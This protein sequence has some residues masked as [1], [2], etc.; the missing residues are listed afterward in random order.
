[1]GRLIDD[2]L[3]FARLSCQPLARRPIDHGKLVHHAWDSL[4]VQREGRDIRFCVGMLPPGEGDLALLR[5]VWIN[6][7]ANA[8]K[9]SRR[10]E[11]AV[12]EVGSVAGEDGRVEY[13]VRDNGAGFDMRYSHKLFGVFE[14]L[15]H[16]DEFEGTGVGLAIVQ[17][18]VTRH[19][20]TVRA[21]GEPGRGATFCFT[22][23]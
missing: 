15:H 14:R 1:M 2:L 4:A 20:S 9:Y 22:L 21:E 7:L 12:I 3:N 8:V 16:A 5:Q 6:L 13:F 10:R 19:G 18:I 11:P 17:R 23:G